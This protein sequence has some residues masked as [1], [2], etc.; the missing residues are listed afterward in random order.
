MSERKGMDLSHGNDV[1]NVIIIQPLAEEKEDR[2]F[3]TVE[4]MERIFNLS[5]SFE[6]LTHRG[7]MHLFSCGHE[8]ISYIECGGALKI[9]QIK[10]HQKKGRLK[11]AQLIVSCSNHNCKMELGA[12]MAA[13]QLW[14]LLFHLMIKQMVPDLQSCNYIDCLQ[15]VKISNSG[16][17][18]ASKLG[19]ISLSDT[20][21]AGK[22]DNGYFSESAWLEGF[23]LGF[24]IQPGVMTLN[25]CDGFDEWLKFLF[26]KKMEQIKEMLE[27][28]N[29][30]LRGPK[31]KRG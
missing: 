23:A 30:F 25:S 13:D 24:T 16:C 4:K 19:M 18:L 8:P 28:S 29:L 2:R 15:M 17:D 6:G 27:T 5:R 1:E 31:T 7:S 26:L 3:F 21:F 11:N 10:E 14:N 20:I 9:E 22:L 12:F